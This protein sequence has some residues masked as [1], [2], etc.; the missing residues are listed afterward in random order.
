M[1]DLSESNSL[2]K[3][4]LQLLNLRFYSLLDLFP[5][6]YRDEAR[7]RMARFADPTLDSGLNISED[8]ARACYELLESLTR[9][10]ENI[11]KRAAQNDLQPRLDL[12]RDRFDLSGDE[13]VLLTAVVAPALDGRF[14]SLYSLFQNSEEPRMDL[15]LR[16][17]DADENGRYAMAEMLGP[18]GKLIANSLIEAAGN[19]RVPLPST[20]FR[21]APG[22]LSWLDGVPLTDVYQGCAEWIVNRKPTEEPSVITEIKTAVTAI[23]MEESMDNPIPMVSLYGP[24]PER[25]KDA[26][27][28]LGADIERPLLLLDLR[29]F[30]VS[31]VM[32]MLRLAMRDSVLNHG[33]LALMGIDKWIDSGSIFPG[34]LGK[35]F[36]QWQTPLLLL[37][38]QNFVFSANDYS[39][40]RLVLRIAVEGLT[41]TQR[42]GVWKRFLRG[43]PLDS[44][45]DDEHL[46]TL[47]GQ[48]TLNTAQIRSAISTGHGKAVIEDRDLNINDLYEGARVSSMHHLSDLAKKIEARY[49]LKDL[50]LPEKPAMEIDQLISMARNR[51]LVLE[52]WGV[53][54][55][56]VSGRGISAL[57]TGVPGTGKTLTAQ[58]IAGELGL[59]LYRVDL[60][61]IISKYIGETEKNLERIFTEAQNSNVILFFDEADSL[62]GRRSEVSD[63]HDRYANIEVGY[64]L[65]R[66]ETYDGIVLMATNLGAN[67]DEAFARRIHFIIDFP[68]PDEE[69]RLRLWQLL[70]PDNIEKESDIDLTPFAYAFKIAG[71]GIRNAV[72]WAIYEAARSKRPLSRDDLLKG[73]EREYQKMGKVI[74][75]LW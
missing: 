46:R 68:F 11:R 66:I 61:T 5:S 55:K 30:E 50:I 69:T 54:K 9:E 7:D 45:F 53:G 19:V 48:F 70:V 15:L 39:G 36:D 44:S 74:P 71:G 38:R 49:T 43:L 2:I 52:D 75:N 3:N 73:V 40:V 65:Q 21:P 4:Y 18:E 72:V 62:F 28:A 23:L 56:L 24:D 42:V 1:S 47:A 26:A 35:F 37:T 16:L 32:P 12:L 51:S 60:S 59:D 8:E 63:S 33:V 57:F 58:V 14:R 6:E 64:L 13:L 31:D 27:I 25:L 34:A 29:E 67:L 10:N 41:G 20:T 17:L 22:L